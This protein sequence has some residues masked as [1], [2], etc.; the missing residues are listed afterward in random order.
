MMSEKRAQKFHTDDVTFQGSILG[1]RIFWDLASSPSCF[2]G[3][4]FHFYSIIP[5]T[6]NPRYPHPPPAGDVSKM[7][8]IFRLWWFLPV[9]LTLLL[10]MIN[11]EIKTQIILVYLMQW[12]LSI[13]VTQPGISPIFDEKFYHGH[14]S[15]VC[16]SMQRWCP[17]WPSLS[18]HICS[19]L[20]K[21]TTSIFM[22]TATS[23]MLERWI[24][25]SLQHGLIINFQKCKWANVTSI[26]TSTRL[27]SNGTGS[28]KATNI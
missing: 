12:S 5:V 26:D 10:S 27:C 20:K 2:E 6:L 1:Q 23:V 11:Y 22:A 18:I 14:V 8:I 17:A 7:L 13:T 28:P 16:R 3:L 9:S 15:R 25:K 21:Q 24:A 4:N 19:P